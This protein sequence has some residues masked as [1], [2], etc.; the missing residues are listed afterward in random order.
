MKV[1]IFYRYRFIRHLRCYGKIETKELLLNVKKL[2]SNCLSKTR[3]L[4][5]NDDFLAR[6]RTQD[7][8][9]TRRRKL[10]FAGVMTVSLNFLSK[11]LQT[12][13][14]HYFEVCQQSETTFS[15]QAFS[16]ARQHIKPEAFKELFQLTVDEALQSDALSYSC[17]FRLF[18][19]S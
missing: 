19:R 14:D 15:Q 17:G 11:S 9:F 3:Q 18:G 10:D 1:E 16:K 7:S 5:S 6:S 12:E 8:F 2:A 13:L 4:F